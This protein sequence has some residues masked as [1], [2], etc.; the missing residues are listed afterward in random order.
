[1]RH[2]RHHPNQHPVEIPKPTQL[3]HPAPFALLNTLHASIPKAET[4]QR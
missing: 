4:F 1:M 2:P 3:L